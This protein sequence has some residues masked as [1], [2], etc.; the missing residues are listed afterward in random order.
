MPLEDVAL[1]PNLHLIVGTTTCGAAVIVKALTEIAGSDVTFRF[2]AGHLWKVIHGWRLKNQLGLVVID[3]L[4]ILP[5]AAQLLRHLE[6]MRV[7][8]FWGGEHIPDGCRVLRIRGLA[9][10]ECVRL[11]R[12]SLPESYDNPSL[13][14]KVI[15]NV[16]RYS[17]YPELL[18]RVLDMITD[19]NQI[20]PID[21]VEMEKEL[22]K[23]LHEDSDDQGGVDA[24]MVPVWWDISGEELADMM[25]TDVNLQ[26]EPKT[27]RGSK[28]R[29]KRKWQGDKTRQRCTVRGCKRLAMTNTDS[30]GRK[31][32]CA[33]H[34]TKTGGRYGDKF[35]WYL[36][37]PKL[38][39]TYVMSMQL[40]E[41][42]GERRSVYFEMIKEDKGLVKDCF[43]KTK[44]RLPD[45]YKPRN[46]IKRM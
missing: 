10:E 16:V 24:D 19:D 45:V 23:T 11:V 38:F 2:D 31:G 12:Q 14:D 46:K 5:E 25:D 44:G 36:R 13:V 37:D 33:A 20:F 3:K 15:E 40:P 6:G 8:A 39:A 1:R 4:D 35:R 28:P 7:V 18:R 9:T 41:D 26:P 34:A 27:E 17:G 43:E 22:S 29:P 30:L 32:R 42:I 21:Q